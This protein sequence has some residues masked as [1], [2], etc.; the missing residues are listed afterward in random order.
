MTGSW[1]DIGGLDDIPAPGARVVK[2][3]SGDAAV[4]RTADDRVFALRDQC[5]TRA[6]RSARASSMAHR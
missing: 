2:T 3:N 4:F 1:I 5:P 6:G